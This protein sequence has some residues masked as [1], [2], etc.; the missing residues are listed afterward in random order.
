MTEDT[1]TE[2]NVVGEGEAAEE[3]ATDVNDAEAAEDGAPEA[4]TEDVA[5]S[6]DVD[7]DAK[8]GDEGDSDA[9]AEEDEEEA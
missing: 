6:V 4:E 2:E 9:V 3:T 1:N 7:N 5:A 8:G